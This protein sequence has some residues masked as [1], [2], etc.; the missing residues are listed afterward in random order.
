MFQL[1]LDSFQLAHIP[2]FDLFLPNDVPERLLSTSI[3][4]YDR[5]ILIQCLMITIDKQSNE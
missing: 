2:N 5:I 4:V 1:F 3:Y